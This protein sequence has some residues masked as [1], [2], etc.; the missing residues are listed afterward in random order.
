MISS[1]EKPPR[2]FIA[3]ADAVGTAE[4][5]P[6]QQPTHE[7]T[8]GTQIESGFV[9]EAHLA[10]HR[11]DSTHLPHHPLDNFVAVWCYRSSET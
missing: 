5:V 4:Q 6:T 7:C 8:F 11:P 9:E 1:Q 10:E 2:R 3:G